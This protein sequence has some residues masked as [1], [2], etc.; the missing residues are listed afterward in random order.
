MLSFIFTDNWYNSLP[1]T[2]YMSFRR[3][4]ITDTLTSGRKYIPEGV[5]K[6]K[7][8]KG[9]MISKSFNDIS[10]IKWKDKRDVCMIT[11]AFVPELVESVNRHE[12]SKQKPN[13]IQVYNQIKPGIHQFDQMLSYHSVLRKTV[14]WYKKVWIHIFEIS[15][16]NSFYL[17][18]KNTTRSKFPEIKEFK[19]SIIRVFIGP[20]KLSTKIQPQANFHYLCVMPTT[21]KKK[22][23][24]R[25]WK[26]FSTKENRKESR[27]QCLECPGQPTLWIDQCFHLCHKNIGVA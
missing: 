19:E 25:T 23:L 1:L 5:M 7:L 9:E 12:N 6:K 16:A 4:Y 13:A 10:M 21:E 27:S 26:H 22:I 24:T 20:V 3:T 17:Y 18:V 8:K 11:N 15:M 14:R 2:K